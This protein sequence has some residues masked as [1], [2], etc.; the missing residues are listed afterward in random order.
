MTETKDEGET[1]KVIQR[2]SFSST[3]VWTNAQTS[4]SPQLTPAHTPPPQL[5]PKVCKEE[6]HKSPCVSN[7]KKMVKHLIVKM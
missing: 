2:H 1:E 4:Q 7:L 3:C 5:T 6:E